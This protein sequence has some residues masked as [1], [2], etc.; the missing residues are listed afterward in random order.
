MRSPSDALPR[1]MLIEW[2]GQVWDADCVK[3]EGPWGVWYLARNDEQRARF[4]FK[5]D[6]KTPS[7]RAV[8]SRQELRDLEP[9]LRKMKPETLDT[10]MSD[11][12]DVKRTIGAARVEE[13]EPVKKARR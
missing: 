3:F 9:R 2:N 4:A 8:F 11:A 7:G 12:L 13:I 6:G 5:A 10:F 1:R